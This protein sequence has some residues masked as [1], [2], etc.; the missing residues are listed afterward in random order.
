MKLE[1]NPKIQKYIK[2]FYKEEDITSKYETLE[3]Y[4]KNDQNPTIIIKDA[5][6]VIKL[7]NVTFKDNHENQLIITANHDM[8]INRL[9]NE[10]CNEIKIYSDEKKEIQ[11]IYNKKNIKHDDQSTLGNYFNIDRNNDIFISVNDKKNVINIKNVIFTDNHGD[12]VEIFINKTLTIYK[13]I[14]EYFIK[15][16]HY[17]LIDKGVDIQFFY[18]KK[19]LDIKDKTSIELLFQ[20]DA[21][22]IIEVYDPDE[23]LLINPKAIYGVTFESS[24]G[25]KTYIST[26]VGNTME[27]LLNDF[28]D[29]IEVSLNDKNKLKFLYKG[30]L[31]NEKKCAI[32]Y[33]KDE[34]N[35]KILVIDPN[36]L[37]INTISNELGSKINIIFRTS[38][39]VITNTFV[40]RGI[41]IDKLLKYYLYRV[42][43]AEYIRSGEIFFIYNVSLLKFG[44]KRKLQ[45]VFNFNNTYDNYVKIQVNFLQDYLVG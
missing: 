35:H 13:L 34:P 4:F 30:E 33:F 29:Y 26:N 44:D 39:G 20:N 23:L 41:T 8:T 1:I 28:L 38:K 15:V 2:F 31:I 5:E 7:F 14:K 9:L 19:N 45:D 42:G 10:Y 25:N 11:F 37:V 27:K 24:Q 22:P 17:E 16:K 36:G 18:I 43:G 3:Q 32:K 6:N 12:K 40:N 21:N